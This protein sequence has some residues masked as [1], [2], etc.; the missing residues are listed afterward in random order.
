M[1][2]LVGA[3]VELIVSTIKSSRHGGPLSLTSAD[4]GLEL[5]SGDRAGR[6][7]PPPRGCWLVGEA[8]RDICTVVGIL[9]FVVFG[10]LRWLAGRSGLVGFR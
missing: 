2:W 1:F 10:W 9:V 5:A 7:D 4:P 8:L 6:V 3:E